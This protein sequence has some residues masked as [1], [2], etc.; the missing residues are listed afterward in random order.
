MRKQ[1]FGAM[2]GLVLACGA[3]SQAQK[4]AYSCGDVPNPSEVPRV[5]PLFQSNTGL[6]DGEFDCLAW[7]DFIYLNWPALKGQRGVPNKSARFGAA[8]PTVWESYKT[9][10]ETFLPNGQ[11]PG[12]WN[13]PH[14]LATLNRSLAQRIAS[15]QVR[16]LTMMSK[17]SRQVMANILSSTGD[18]QQFLNEIAQAGGGILY[19]LNGYPV[20]YEVAMDEAQYDYIVHN[21]LYDAGKQFGFAL[22]NV[23]D[24]PAGT[25]SKIAALELKAAWKVMSNAEKNSGRFY[26]AQAVLEGSKSPVT[27]GLVG[28]H[29]FIANGAQG[30]WA[31]FAQMDNAPV[32][33][34]ASSGTFNFFNPNC[35][36]PGTT[37]PCPFNVKDADPGQ[38]VQIT[39]DDPTAVRLNKY[40]RGVLTAYDPK[41]PWQYYKLV[42]VQWATLPQTLSRLKAPAKVPLPDGKPN[43]PTFVNAVLETFVQKPGVG[44]FACHQYASVARSGGLKANFAT[45]YSFM[46]G[47]ATS[48]APMQ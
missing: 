8:G 19:D 48:P 35:K 5:A 4:P 20:Y 12:P 29:M 22:I 30:A 47:H 9:V 45:S 24:L 17:I 2:A 14:L 32:V 11:N 13:Q 44:C 46:F 16:H 31:T 41:T 25:A 21:G 38:V 39:P 37:T 10:D 26:T 42:N 1:F 3:S 23:I 7:Q 6:S 18:P 40:M 43:N 28:F 27:V 34:A 15:G 33:K 36:L